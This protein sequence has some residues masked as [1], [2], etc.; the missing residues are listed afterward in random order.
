MIIT[1]GPIEFKL[2][3]EIADLLGI[4]EKRTVEI[5][6]RRTWKSRFFSWPWRPWI[7]TVSFSVEVAEPIEVSTNEA[8][9]LSLG[10]TLRGSDDE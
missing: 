10:F 8:G 9:E 1:G 2:N 7:K 6:Y 3:E 4:A 5:I